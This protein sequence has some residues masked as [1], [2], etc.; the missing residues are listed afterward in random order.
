MCDNM[1]VVE[2]VSEAGQ[3]RARQG[4][5]GQGRSGSTNQTMLTV[6]IGAPQAL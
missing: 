1:G 2:E 6:N 4:K 5:A 3:G